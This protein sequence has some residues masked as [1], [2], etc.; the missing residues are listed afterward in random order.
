MLRSSKFGF[1][2][3][4]ATFESASVDLVLRLSVLLLMFYAG[5]DWRLDVPLK[6]LC[7]VA[8]LAR[9]VLRSHWWW[10][11]V[12]VLLVYINANSWHSIDNHKYLITYWALSI[13][14]ALAWP[15]RGTAIL[16]GNAR[17]LIGLCFAFAVLW[18]LLGGEYLDGS[19][20][21][22]TFLTDSRVAVPVSL[23]GGVPL[24]ELA[25]N[26]RLTGMMAVWPS[27]GAVASLH[28]STLMEYVAWG[29][30]MWTLLIEGSIAVGWTLSWLRRYA[31]KDVALIAFIATTYGILPV[32]GFAT[33]LGVM[34]CTLATVEGRRRCMAAYLVVLTLAQLAAIPWDS[35]VS[36]TVLRRS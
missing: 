19:F 7:A 34:G 18:K 24:A 14:T 6:V 33:V 3:S 8:L 20:L 2:T 5:S 36:E 9:P 31:F 35:Y 30:S 25:A 28:T 32:V 17:G 27:E 26:R 11:A 22:H 1:D 23:V 16:A 10:L 29:V 4:P 13:A 12:S 15:S 21:H